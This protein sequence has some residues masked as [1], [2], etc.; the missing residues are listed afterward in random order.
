MY[1]SEELKLLGFFFG[2]KP[3]VHKQVDKIA[4]KAASRSF[5]IRH[6]CSI[7]CNK[8]LRNVYCSIV[9]SVIE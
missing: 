2:D 4:D 3:T 5:V 6:L 1:L 9:R 7:N 8:K